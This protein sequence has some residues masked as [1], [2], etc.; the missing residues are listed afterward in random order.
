VLLRHSVIY[1]LSNL[2]TGVFGLATAA[3][4]T[5]VLNPTS[6]G[7][8]GLGIA[9]AL[10]TGSAVFDWHGASFLRFVQSHGDRREAMATFLALFGALSIGVVL[11]VVLIQTTGLLSGYDAVLLVGVISGI[12][13][14]W[15]QF[16]TRSHMADFEAGRA[17]RMNLARGGLAFILSLAVALSTHD[18]IWVLL[19]AT[20]AQIAG[21]S[22]Y[23]ISG[24]SVRPAKFHPSLARQV[25]RF[26]YPLAISAILAGLVMIVG[27]FMLDQLASAEAVGR[28]TAATLLVQ[29]SL[30]MVAAGVGTASYPLV[31]KAMES[32]DPKVVNRQLTQNLALLLGVLLPAAIGLVLVSPNLAPLLVGRDFVEAVIVLTPWLAGT[33]VISSIRSYYVDYAFQF[34]GKT[35]Y[36]ALTHAAVAVLNLGLNLVLIPLR[37]ELG[38][39]MAQLFAVAPSLVLAVVLSRRAFVVPL[40]LKVSGQVILASGF[41]AAAL[42]AVANLHGVAGL[43]AQVAVGAVVYAAALI[44][45]NFMGIRSQ[46]RQ[47]ATA[48]AGLCRRPLEPVSTSEPRQRHE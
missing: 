22:I 10:F 33:A 48:I 37:G 35:S 27:R 30:H 38:A 21:A 19:S 42:L 9:V 15:F 4:L 13:A 26:G 36:L 44:A 18:A 31:L 12:T 41:M 6:Y 2:A 3:M 34:G 47:R 46:I 39:A 11:L 40:P 25:L 28:F 1:A 8:Y 43:V 20:V 32:N 23:K 29:N 5:R 17:F 45:L 16:A 24:A 14:A 7:T